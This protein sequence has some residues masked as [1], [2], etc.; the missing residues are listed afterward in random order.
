[1]PDNLFVRGYENM[2]ENL[3]HYTSIEK[4]AL[5]LKNKTIKFTNLL[6]VDD[7]EEA[8]TE[9]LGLFGRN[10]LVSCW[11]K[12]SEDILPMWNMYT[13]E[14]KGVRIG[15]KINPFKKYTY[16]SGE[17]YFS[18]NAASY[19]NY[20]D[21]YNKKVSI[22]AGCPITVEVAYTN[23]KE[24]LYPRIKSQ[25]DN[26]ISISLEKL[27]KYKREC[28]SFQKEYRYIITTAPWSIKELEKIRS[29]EEHVQLFSRLFDDGN[30]QFCDEIFLELADDAF[31]NM[32]ILLGPK[33][34][35]AESII[36]QAL[37]EKYCSD[38]CVKLEKSRI[39]I[40]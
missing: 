36:V 34:T 27:G 5:I 21:N 8:E 19:I 11:T 9:D 26:E 2:S 33:S 39:R 37:L 10:C 1:M 3:Y 40:R 28:W 4:L 31:E 15:M 32:E 23:D 30:N 12:C 20:Y 16:N 24:L 35:E 22:A 17:E 14:M 29:I 18:E 7:P 13:P 38:S 6:N 25:T